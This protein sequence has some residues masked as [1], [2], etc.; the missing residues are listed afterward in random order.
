[1]I[2]NTGVRDDTVAETLRHADGAI[3]GSYFKIDG[4]TWNAVDPDRVRRLVTAA[5]EV[6][7]GAAG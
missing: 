7:D 4:N 3:V 5:A 1:V 2:A 6:R